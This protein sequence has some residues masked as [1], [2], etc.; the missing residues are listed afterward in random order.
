MLRVVEEYETVP[1]DACPRELSVESSSPAQGRQT[2]G[3]PWVP[4]PAVAPIL[5]LK[6]DLSPCPWVCPGDLE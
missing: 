2:L 3:Q 5:E 6:E 4:A 1:A